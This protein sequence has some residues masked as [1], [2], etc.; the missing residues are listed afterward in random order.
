MQTLNL[1]EGH[2]VRL[3][4]LW[5]PALNRDPDVVPSNGHICPDNVPAAAGQESW[6]G[7]PFANVHQYG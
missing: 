7:A 5:T 2:H 3:S 1:R 6:E 4:K